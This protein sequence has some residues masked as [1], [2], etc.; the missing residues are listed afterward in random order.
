MKN[1]IW[2][3][4]GIATCL[5]TSTVADALAGPRHRKHL[6]HVDRNH[7][8]V[9]TAKELKIDRKFKHKV[10]SKV[11]RPWEA[12]AD[13]N[14]DGQVSVEEHRAYHKS[15][16]DASQDGTLDSTE[17]KRFWLVQRFKVHTPS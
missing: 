6:K 14:N 7:D 9:V 3:I 16:M 15:Q 11:N 17:R 2:I 12:K 4:A 1:K 10:K 13:T 8:G 5:I